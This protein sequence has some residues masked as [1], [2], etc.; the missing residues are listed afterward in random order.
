MLRTL[1]ETARISQGLSLSGRGAG[2]QPGDWEL[3]MG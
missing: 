1:S 3:Q 2:A